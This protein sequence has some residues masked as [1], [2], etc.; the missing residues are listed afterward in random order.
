MPS[1]SWLKRGILF[2]SGSLRKFP[3][4]EEAQATSVARYVRKPSR[5]PQP[6]L[7]SDYNYRRDPG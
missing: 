1:E 6:Q 2:L 4:S 7:L 3:F 5:L